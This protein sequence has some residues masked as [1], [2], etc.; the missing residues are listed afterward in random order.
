MFWPVEQVILS[1]GCLQP[2]PLELCLGREVVHVVLI[3]TRV[4]S[5]HV[6]CFAVFLQL[7]F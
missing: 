1:L 5:R 4:K 6:G 2:H 3:A 7:L